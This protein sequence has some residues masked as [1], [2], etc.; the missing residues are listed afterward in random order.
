MK[1]VCRVVV[2]VCIALL[3]VF[4]VRF[5][6]NVRVLREQIRTARDLPVYNGEVTDVRVTYLPRTQKVLY[7]DKSFIQILYG[8]EIDGVWT[9]IPA[10]NY[11]FYCLYKDGG[12]QCSFRHSSRSHIVRIG[13][14]ALIC[15]EAPYG[16]PPPYDTIGTTPM[17]P[18]REFTEKNRNI[19]PNPYFILM[20][21]RT[22][23]PVWY[24]E[25]CIRAGLVVRYYLILDLKTLPDDYELHYVMRTND[26]VTLY[27]GNNMEH[28]I[29]KS[30]LMGFLEELDTA[31]SSR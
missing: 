9:D 6:P 18:F 14:Y 8:Y 3:A 4:V 16:A 22:H 12:T 25:E 15:I 26:E 5:F 21:D 27:S 28:I 23:W 24:L 20:E 11:P 13:D 7:P 2:R 19:D 31:I 30:E 17:E 10:E 29:T 1:K